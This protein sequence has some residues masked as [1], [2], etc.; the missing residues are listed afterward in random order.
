MSA[1][2]GEL[3]TVLDSIESPWRINP[4]PPLKAAPMQF[5][6]PEAGETAADYRAQLE[7]TRAQLRPLQNKLIAG[8]Q[9]SILLVFQ[10]LDAAGKDGAIREVL[11]GL[12]VGSIRVASFKRPSSSELAHDFMWRT[13]KELPERGQIGAFNRSYYEEVLAVRVH[14]EFLNGQYAGHPPDST[15]LWPARYRAIREFEKHLAM[16]NTLVLKFWLNVSPERQAM[17][18]L[19]RLEDEEKR[20]KFSSSDIVESGFRKDYDEAVMHM[21]NE[22][23]RPGAPWFCV[24]ADDRWFLRWQIFTILLQALQALPMTYPDPESLDA[25]EIKTLRD[26]LRLR[27]GLESV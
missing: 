1:L 13:T 8:K 19:D 6:P 16:S 20:W 2:P 3:E 5:A 21:L 15:L 9:F 14:P 11:S 25:E 7:Q 24:P 4:S 18:F 12:D 17:R 22:T 23:S 27:A 10:A 26:C